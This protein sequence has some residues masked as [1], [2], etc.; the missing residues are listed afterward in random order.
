MI[1]FLC[2]FLLC[3]PLA[4]QLRTAAD[5]GRAVLAAGLDPNECY[6]IRDVEI[7]EEDAR[8][9]LTEGYLVFGRPVNGAPLTAA[10]SADTEG[11]DGEILLLPPGQSERK[12]MAAYTGA[13][14][15]NE[16]FAQAAFFFTET[17][18][19][20]LLETVRG[21]GARRTPDIGA[22]MVER[23]GR[24]VANIMSSFESRIV[25]DL[26][27]PGSGAGY[28]EAVIH[29]KKLGDFDVLYDSRGYEQI[30]AGQITNR[31]G[32]M[33]WDTWSSFAARD[34]RGKPPADPEE[35]IL[36]YRIEA[37]L[38]ASLNM[39]CV[40]HMKVRATE[41]SRNLLAFDLSGKM[42]ATA[43][44]IDG[45]PAEVYE[46]DSVRSG[47]VQNTGNELLLV[48]PEQP[49]EPGS[50][51]E[52]EIEHEGQVVQDTGHQI[53]F[54]SA[55]GTWYPG[56]GVQFADCDVTWRYP[57]GLQL[58]SPGKTTEDRIE[59]DTHITRRVPEGPVRILGFNLGQYER[60]DSA[61][62]G[63]AVEVLANKEV[64]D[65]LR[66]R[67]QSAVSIAEPPGIG[68]KT[69][70]MLTATAPA[71]IPPPRPA[72]QL[73]SIADQIEDSM[74]WFRA[75]FGEP[76]V[77]TLTVSPQP[78]NFGQG[79]AGMIYLPTVNYLVNERGASNDSLFFR[80]LLVAHE[81]AHQWWGNV[82]TSGSYHHEW[83]MEAL[84]N[85]S[86]IMY[87]ESKQGPKAIEIAL[88]QYRKNLFAKGPDG[89]TAESEG[90]LVQGRRLEGS[91]N[92]NAATAVMYG[93]GSW[94]LHMLR[95]RMGDE[96]FLKALGEARRRFEWKPLDTDAFRLLCAQFMPAGSK[97]AKLENFFDQWVYGTGV[98]TLKLSYSVKGTKLTGTVTQSD[99]PDDFSVAVPVE[100]QTGKGKLVQTV[101]TSSDEPV[102][103]SVN[104]VSPNAK[105]VLD[106]GWSV[107]RR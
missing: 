9:Y 18:A 44:R 25:L 92:P 99:A 57:A 46:R 81:A 12:S 98:P 58:V 53:Y 5:L 50:E 84:A 54:V 59:G 7:A 45:R 14:N 49:L 6:R 1:R 23:W 22:I 105:A 60:K 67:P 2:A 34:R 56:R 4:A 103:F 36:S 31:N 15:L 95:R 30:V 48:L 101:R 80:D 42:R 39:H 69:G 94:V 74:A 33:L 11:G 61:K 28:F 78:T 65:I 100:I 37:T 51:H 71:P 107:L 66:P 63:I 43:A 93:K 82:V 75:R 86:A 96:N 88:E 38:D 64:E 91:N 104:V 10:F 72:A 87:L 70:P 35:R 79:F 41:A 21:S 27:T 68:R 90:P 52:I 20:S 73:T 62:N 3:V 16:H 40:T 26:L 102:T 19:R 77:T 47:L 24:V 89:E 106:P 83:L 29:G 76:P 55:R 97:D 32:R 85:Y 8:F 13:P 17:G